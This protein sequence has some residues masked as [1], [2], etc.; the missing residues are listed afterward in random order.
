[1][2][3]DLKEARRLLD[4]LKNPSVVYGDVTGEGDVTVDDALLALQ[5]AVGKIQLTEQQT[6]A[7]DVDGTQGVTVSDALLILQKAV[8]KIEGLPIEG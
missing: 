1:M 4:E 6:K 7:A 3:A 5:G 8:G 2:I